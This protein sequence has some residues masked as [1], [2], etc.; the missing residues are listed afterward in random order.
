LEL[1]HEARVD[2]GAQ[3]HK[4][5]VECEDPRGRETI[6]L[7]EDEQIVREL[8]REILESCG[9]RVLVAE[10]GRE[11]LLKSEG[12]PGRIPLL[13]TDV[14]MPGMSGPALAERLLQSRPEVR[15]LYMSGYTDDFIAHDGLLDVD[16]LFIQKPFA[17]DDLA[18][19]VRTILGEAS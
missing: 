16:V 13:I 15:V 18:K 2:E 8:I 3:L 19:K 5:S 17:A 9:Y 6:L 12:H 1:F 10:N 11:A 4:R 14:V 7:A